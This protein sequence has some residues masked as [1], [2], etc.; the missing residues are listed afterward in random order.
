M[1]GDTG[2]LNASTGTVRP[3][4]RG[5]F[6]SKGGDPMIP[7][8]WDGL[9]AALRE[10]DRRDEAERE[11]VAARAARRRTERDRR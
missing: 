10:E 9:V 11:R 7:A 3:P 4:S 5:R 6:Y 1:A 8:L 2:W